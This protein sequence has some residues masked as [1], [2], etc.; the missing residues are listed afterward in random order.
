MAQAIIELEADRL[1]ERAALIA[2]HWEAA[3]V[4]LEAANWSARA[5]GWAGYNDQALA[6]LYWRKVRS[7]AAGLAASPEATQLGITAAVMILALGWRLGGLS[8]EG[9]Q[10]FEDEA[11]QIYTEG[12]RLAESAGSGNEATPAALVDGL[13]HCPGSDG[14]HRRVPAHAGGSRPR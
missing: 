4:V 9:G 2:H 14:S 10:Y 8:A 3:G 11:I 1:D 13:R 5:A 12:R 7:L 6:T